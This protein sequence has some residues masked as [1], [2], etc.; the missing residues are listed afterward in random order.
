M[1]QLCRLCKLTYGIV[2][3]T[4]FALNHVWLCILCNLSQF[5]SFLIVSDVR[6]RRGLSTKLC[7][8][9]VE[10]VCY[11]TFFAVFNKVMFTFQLYISPPN[12]KSSIQIMVHIGSYI[13]FNIE[14]VA[15]RYRFLLLI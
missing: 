2:F 3:I 12:I 9:V 8:E 11:W 1:V 10:V 15:A 6:S 7:H 5:L 4:C 13:L 14:L